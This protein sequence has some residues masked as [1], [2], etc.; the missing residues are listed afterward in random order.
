MK[1]VILTVVLAVLLLCVPVKAQDLTTWLWNDE[2]ATGAR[3][4]YCWDNIEAGVS[5][6][7]LTDENN[8]KT[9]GVF[10]VRRFLDLIKLPNPVTLDFLPEE[11]LGTPYIGARIDFDLDTNQSDLSPITGVL[12]EE[13]FFV[14]NRW[15]DFSGAPKGLYFGLRLLFKF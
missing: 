2:E 14:E 9:M 6:M 13:I 1:K 4:G 8:P 3:I 15:S 7:W 11:I 12:F 5:A 10:A